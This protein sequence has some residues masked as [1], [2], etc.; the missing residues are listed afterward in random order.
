MGPF[1]LAMRKAV[2]SAAGVP[3][4]SGAALRGQGVEALLDAVV[5]FLP[6]PACD[7]AGALCG[8]IGRA[9]V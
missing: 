9:H 2:R 8:E 1:R 4:L 6:P 3:V 7:A 5:D